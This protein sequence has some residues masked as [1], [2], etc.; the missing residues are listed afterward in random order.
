[1][2]CRIGTK[3]NI[4]FRLLP[5]LLP[6]SLYSVIS[7]LRENFRE[8]Y[9][10]GPEVL[11]VY[12]FRSKN[13]ESTQPV[14][15]FTLTCHPYIDSWETHTKHL[16]ELQVCVFRFIH[17]RCTNCASIF[18]NPLFRG[19]LETHAKHHARLQFHLFRSII[20]VRTTPASLL[21]GLFVPFIRG[22]WENPS[23]ATQ[24]NLVPFFQV[25]K[26]SEHIPCFNPLWPNYPLYQR[27]P[28]KRMPSISGGF[29]YWSPLIQ[30]W[31]PFLLSSLPQLPL[32]QRPPGKTI[33]SILGGF[34]SIYSDFVF[35]AQLS[36]SSEGS[37]ETPKYL[38]RF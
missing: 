18:I 38:R 7:H 37:C 14:S 24:K 2:I 6:L 28:G 1:M 31:Q 23:K 4:I 36:S 27:P 15:P 29:M 32:P 9:A 13:S 22:L 17:S 3:E 30:C 21:L 19:H 10:K 35:L 5:F 11:Q 26:F 20:S 25:H 33:Q 8:T 34:T 16:K 12:V